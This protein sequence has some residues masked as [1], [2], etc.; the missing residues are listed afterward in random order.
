MSD[1]PATAATPQRITVRHYQALCGLALAAILLLLFQQSSQSILNPAL[2]LLI[3]VLVLVVGGAG[4]LY[5]V[6]LS[7]MVIMIGIAAPMAIE[8]YYGNLAFNPDARPTRILDIADM[9]MC[10][11]GLVFF[12]GY[13]R[14]HGLWFGILPPD[15]RQPASTSGPP[16]RR[17]ETSLSLAELAP[18]VLVVP[19]LALLAELACLVLKLPW[20][21]VDLPPRWR[22][23]LLV[24]WTILLG[25]TLAAQVFRYWRRVQMDRTTALI[26]LQDILW[27]ETRGE[28]RRLQR[29][30]AWRKKKS[31]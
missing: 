10:M 19:A 17:S 14:L 8:Q 3:H 29:W 23:L 9:L 22:Q 7:P 31:S 25:L 13:Y 28:Q 16:G 21:A 15:A 20:T 12:L 5:P 27:H 24:A 30:R 26:M 18:L 1:V 4:I 2:V 11:A 6:R